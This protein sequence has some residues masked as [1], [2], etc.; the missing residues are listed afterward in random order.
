MP[1]GM[2]T[3]STPDIVARASALIELIQTRYHEGHRRAL[4]D[5]L[6]D[7]AE[8]EALGGEAGIVDALQ[9]FAKA[10]EQH[11]FK[12][13]MRLFPMMEQGG[14][15]LIR[16][17]IEDMDREHREHEQALRRLQTSL[18]AMPPA[19]T[20]DAAR[21]RLVEGFDRL[22]AELS[23]HIRTEDELLFALFAPPA[24]AGAPGAA[25]P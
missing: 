8:V 9:G 17:L 22:A 21:H 23:D 16:H 6:A 24:A 14:N 2:R 10:L 25:G 11:M 13:E 5:L 7:A 1:A 4:V 12:E 19:A 3:A 15:T 18:H 20:A